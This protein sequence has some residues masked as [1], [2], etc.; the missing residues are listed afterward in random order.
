MS[1]KTFSLMLKTEEIKIGST[2]YREIIKRMS[3]KVMP[4]TQYIQTT[5]TQTNDIKYKD[6]AYKIKSSYYEALQELE[7]GIKLSESSL[8][9]V[10]FENSD[11]SKKLDSAWNL[12]WMVLTSIDEGKDVLRQAESYLKNHNYQ[13]AWEKLHQFDKQITSVQN[14]ISAISIEIKAA[15]QME[16]KFQEKNKVCFLFWCNINDKNKGLDLKIKDLEFRVK[17]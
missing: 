7:S 15:K 9:G 14:H 11:A 12:R 10:V 17:S 4:T 3:I 6:P 13:K 5:N 2:T 16:D 8:S 1:T